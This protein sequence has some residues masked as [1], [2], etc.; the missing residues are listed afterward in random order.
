MCSTALSDSVAKN[1]ARTPTN[2]TRAVLLR[3]QMTKSNVARMESLAKKNGEKTMY[4]S[5]T[6]A[7]GIN[8]L[9]AQEYGFTFF[10]DCVSI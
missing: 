2:M 8:A 1:S 6:L 10:D 7:G 5:K 9:G 4:T 3:E